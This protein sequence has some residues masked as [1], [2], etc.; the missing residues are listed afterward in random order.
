MLDLEVTASQILDERERPFSHDRSLTVGASEIGTCARRVWFEKKLG[1]AG[2]DE[3]YKPAWGAAARGD[4]LEEQWSVPVVRKAIEAV[5]GKLIWAGAGQQ[6][7]IEVRNWFMSATPDGLGINLP[8]NFLEKYGVT[9]LLGTSCVVELKSFDPRIAKWSLPKPEHVDQLI[10]QMGLIRKEG[11]YEPRWG[12][13]V[14]VNASWL[15]DIR[16]FPVFFN[17]L[18]FEGQ[19]RRAI[20][21]LQATDADQLRPEGVIAGK[22]ECEYCPFKQRCAGYTKSVPRANLGM[23]DIPGH[24]RNMVRAA[25]TRWHNARQELIDV[26]AREDGAK[27]MLKEALSRAGTRSVSGK[28]MGYGKDQTYDF[29]VTWRVT[30]P[31]VTWN[32][33]KVTELIEQSGKQ[34][35][36]FQKIG[37]PGDML[38]IKVKDDVHQEKRI[39]RKDQTDQTVVDVDREIDET[40]TETKLRFLK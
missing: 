19:I 3:D 25:V 24:Q 27:A 17:R 35:S 33:D 26:V 10:A 2:W 14:Y 16:I 9:D 4:I 37:K 38:I 29:D 36:D 8:K 31:R 7:T 30:K 32:E 13:I 28:T 11:T 15:D 12:I 40:D 6:H 20:A 18:A 34:V 1:K 39:G 21:I 23:A 22:K 5:G